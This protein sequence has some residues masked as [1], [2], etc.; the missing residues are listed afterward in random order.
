MPGL[1][2]Q[3]RAQDGT[4]YRTVNASWTQRS[5]IYPGPWLATPCL[6]QI[7]LG[8]TGVRSRLQSER[9]WYFWDIASGQ[10]SEVP[11]EPFAALH[12]VDIVDGK[13]FY[14]DRARRATTA[15]VAGCPSTNSRHLG[16]RQQIG[17][18][19]CRERV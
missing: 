4:V 18:A 17:R 13:V 9:A 16:R 7:L 8:A 10:A 3:P 11:A 5:L 14:S 15:A 19:S 12:S 2:L 6:L 1:Q